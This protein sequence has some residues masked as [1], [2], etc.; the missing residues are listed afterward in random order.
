VF[1]VQA[2]YESCHQKT[3]CQVNNRDYGNG[4]RFSRNFLIREANYELYHKK[5]AC[6]VLKNKLNNQGDL[7]IKKT[8]Q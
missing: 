5:K 1:C 7:H 4:S 6:Q 3:F 2:D 8:E